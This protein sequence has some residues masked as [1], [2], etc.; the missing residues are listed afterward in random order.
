MKYF[1]KLFGSPSIAH[2]I[3]G[4]YNPPIITPAKQLNAKNNSRNF[5]IS[6][7]AWWGWEEIDVRAIRESETERIAR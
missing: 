5:E 6:L 2:D 1:V 4:F 3:T 7:W